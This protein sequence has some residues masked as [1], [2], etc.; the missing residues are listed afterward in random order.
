MVKNLTANV[1]DL[2]DTGSI[3]GLGRSPGGEHCNP[4]QGNPMDRRAQ[5]ATALGVSKSQTQLSIHNTHTH[6]K[7]PIKS[8]FPHLITSQNSEFSSCDTAI[9]PLEQKSQILEI[10]CLFVPGERS[11]V[12]DMC[13]SLTSVVVLYLPIIF[14]TSESS[15]QL[16][17]PWAASEKVFWQ[18]TRKELKF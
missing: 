2:R 10:N 15:F 18:A 4:L 16:T 8:T 13:A 12:T 1:E 9:I 5:W 14:G 17:S 6:I 7:I 11:I 3:P